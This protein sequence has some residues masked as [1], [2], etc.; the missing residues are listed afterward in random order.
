MQERAA[1]ARHCVFISSAEVESGARGIRSKRPLE[2]HE[3]VISVDDHPG[4]FWAAER[5]KFVDGVENAS[6]SEQH[7]ADEDEVVVAASRPV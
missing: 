4:S 3:R 6:A 7:L 5:S 2:C 1:F